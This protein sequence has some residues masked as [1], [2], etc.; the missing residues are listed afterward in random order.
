MTDALA[1]IPS[2]VD[3]T[4]RLAAGAPVVAAASDGERIITGGDDGKVMATSAGGET[5]VLATD[6]KRRWIDHVAVGPNGALAWSAGRQAFA[7]AG[8]AAEPRA[9]EVP[10]TVGALAFL[11]KG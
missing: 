11:P 9:L 6:A 5:R 10:S 8:D 7:R 2:V 1:N 4:R 3:R